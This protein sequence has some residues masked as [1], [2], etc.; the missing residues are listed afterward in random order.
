MKESCTNGP[1]SLDPLSGRATG[2]YELFCGRKSYSLARRRVTG[3]NDSCSMEKTTGRFTKPT[4]T[5]LR[6]CHPVEWIRENL[7]K[8]IGRFQPRLEVR[9]YEAMSRQLST[10]SQ[11]SFDETGLQ[12]HRLSK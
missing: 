11:S 3:R 8:A 7:A 4:G 5:P 10:M 9:S 1:P 6:F 2:F 12:H